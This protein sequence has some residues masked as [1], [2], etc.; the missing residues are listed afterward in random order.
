MGQICAKNDAGKMATDAPVR[1]PEAKQLAGGGPP[2]APEKEKR[3]IS[4]GKLF[5]T[6]DIEGEAKDA[7]ESYCKTNTEWKYTSKWKNV[8][9]GETEVSFFEVEKLDP[10]EIDRNNK[11]INAVAAKV[12]NDVKTGM[13]EGKVE[14]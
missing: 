10:S 3:W 2:A 4:S 12:Q 1:K 11:L 7:A 8:K 14:E 5:A 6:S 9:E 13:E